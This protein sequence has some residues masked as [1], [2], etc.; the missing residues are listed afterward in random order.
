MK[1]L[2]CYKKPCVFFCFLKI[3][4]ELVSGKNCK[5]SMMIRASKSTVQMS[6]YVRDDQKQEWYD[7]EPIYICCS[8]NEIGDEI[9]DECKRRNISHRYHSNVIEYRPKRGLTE[10]MCKI[11]MFETGLKVRQL[12]DWAITKFN[13]E[14]MDVAEIGI[15]AYYVWIQPQREVFVGNGENNGECVE[16][17]WM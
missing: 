17:W 15:D 6:K 13:D 1:K 4:I 11:Q 2:P 8:S 5:V 14:T 12:V 9:R 7:N 16:H 3:A 10:E